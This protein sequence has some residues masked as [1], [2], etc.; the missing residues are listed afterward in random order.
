M[1]RKLALVVGCS[2]YEDSGFALLDTPDADVQALVKVLRNPEIGSFDEVTALLDQ[3]EP[4]VRREVARFFA[5]KKR[6]DLLLLYFSGHG[7]RD[8]QGD[9]YL[10]VKDTE[11][12]LLSATAIPAA[13][14][15]ARMDSSRSRRQV[16]ILDCCHSGAFARGTK[17]APGASVGTAAAFEGSGYGRWVLTA[18]DTTQFAWE[19]DQVIGEAENSVFTHYLIQGLQTGEADAN[20]DGRIT[21]D[22][23]Y[24]YVYERVVAMT[25]RQTPGKWAYKQRG[26]MVI[27]RNPHPVVRPAPLPA[28]LQQAV[29][30]PLAHVR[31]GVVR[32]LERLLR[33]SHAGLAQ[34]AR[35]ALEGLK[36]DDSRRVSAA[37]T[38]TLAAHETQRAPEPARPE[39]E[40]LPAEAAEGEPETAVRAEAERLELETA[41]VRRRALYGR[42]K[43]VPTWAWAG[44]V[45]AALALLVGLVGLGLGWWSGAGTTEPPAEEPP[46]AGPSLG[47]TWTR[48]ADGMVMVYVP[49]GTFQMGSDESDPDA[50]DDEFP[51]HWVTLESIWMDQTEVTNAQ[52]ERCVSAGAC[53]P[54]ASSQSSTR[55]SYY[56]HR[57]YD[58]YPVIWVSWQD[59]DAYCSWAG[60]RLPTEAE[61]EYAARGPE[62]TIYPWGDNAPD[63]SLANYGGNVG[64]TAEVGSYPDGASWCGALD[65]AGN[66]W[67]WVADWY[68]EYPS[69]RQ[70]NPTGPSSGDARVL[71]GGSW[72]HDR[73]FARCAYRLRLA[74]GFSDDAIGFRCVS[75]AP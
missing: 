75:P 32:E 56:G 45:V 63:E 29:E 20:G 54:L 57:A 47:D 28:E 6:D 18:T 8:D 48:P 34:A 55:D 15:T 72:Y 30:S 22:E 69:G 24:D 2:E 36:D 68:G 31:E 74:P 66:V 40:R 21:L 17:G 35:T 43:A 60:G 61:W 46:F 37:A 14:I 58:D 9:L 5:G 39:V 1:S 7:V 38:E 59:A 41:A 23:L 49:R 44:G 67:E 16:L 65:M 27:A 71:R 19:G 25:P 64:D 52:Y 50:R 4:I 42:L 73:E 3:P 33:G 12:G 10:A 13:F 53:G 70:E 62:G 11:R 51:Q 26:E